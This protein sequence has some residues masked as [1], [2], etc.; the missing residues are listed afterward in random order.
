MKLSET[1]GIRFDSGSSRDSGGVLTF[2]K[3][4]WKC[5][6]KKLQHSF[7]VP[8]YLVAPEAEGSVNQVSGVKMLHLTSPHVKFRRKLGVDPESSES[9]DKGTKTEETEKRKRR[10]SKV[11]SE[12]GSGEAKKTSGEAKKARLPAPTYPK[13]PPQPPTRKAEERQKSPDPNPVRLVAN[14]RDPDS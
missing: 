11:K 10:R 2:T 1:Y 7:Y 3:Q 8:F 14:D 13:E 12:E 5:M 6:L 4:D 9:E